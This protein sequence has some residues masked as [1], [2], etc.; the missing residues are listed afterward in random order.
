MI[1]YSIGHWLGMMGCIGFSTYRCLGCLSAGLL[2]NIAGGIVV[3][4]AYI[5]DSALLHRGYVC[6]FVHLYKQ[7]SA[8]ITL[9]NFA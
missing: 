7:K 4:A 9:R 3:L 1:F 2:A 6:I 8:V 5:L